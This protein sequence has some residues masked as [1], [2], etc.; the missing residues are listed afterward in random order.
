[1]QI[2]KREWMPAPVRTNWGDGMMELLIELSKD[3]TASVFVHVDD[4]PLYEAHVAKGE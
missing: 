1:M 4:I 2:E 3:A